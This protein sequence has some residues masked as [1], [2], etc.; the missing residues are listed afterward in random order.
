MR[1][2]SHATASLAGQCTPDKHVVIIDTDIG[3]DIDDAL[4]LALAVRSPEI[5]LYGVTTVFGDTRRRAYLAAHVLH[6]SGRVDVPVA[7]GIETP[8]QPRGHPSG[9]PQAAVIDDYEPLT[10]STLSGPELIVQAARDHPGQF[11]LICI[12]PLTNVAHALMLAPSLSSS[13]RN[14]IMMGGTASVPLAEWNVRNDV[15]AA[16]MVLGAGIAVTMVGLNVTL[17]CHMRDEDITQLRN[18]GTAQTDLL[19]R[20]LAIWQRERPRWQPRQPFLHDPLAVMALCAPEL[21][22]FAQVPV[23]VLTHGPLRGYMLPRVM[24]GPRVHAAV[25]LHSSTAR[26]WIMHRLLY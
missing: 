6:V 20:L 8:L 9:V 3:D 4:A 11:T 10:L 5:T 24:G 2:N 13:I 17:R 25:D 14:I 21:L 22:R 7:A 23:R 16:R 18:A 12:G 26:E 19:S 1:Q 15:Q